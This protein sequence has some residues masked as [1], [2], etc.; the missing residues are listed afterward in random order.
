MVYR[1]RRLP[2]PE[3]L[4]KIYL[5][6][7]LTGR[8]IAKKY[9]VNQ[10]YVYAE[11]RR[12]K[13]PS[14]EACNIPVVCSLC[15]KK[16]IVQRHRVKAIK[17]R[18][19]SFNHYCSQKCY[20]K[21]RKSSYSIKKRTTSSSRRIVSHHLPFRLTSKMIVHH[22]NNNSHDLDIGNL[23]VFKSQASHASYHHRIRIN[24]N[25]PDDDKLKLPEPLWKGTDA[26][27]S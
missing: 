10:S 18:T 22:V 6:D 17:K 3:K 13:I 2:G 9:K 24:K 7:L 1:K 20:Q 27:F 21:S 8:E 14:K 19:R 15:K 5:E 25:L 11:L 23:W 12:L 4:R 26:T 16:F